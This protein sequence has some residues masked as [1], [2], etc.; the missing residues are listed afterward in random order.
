MAKKRPIETRTSRMAYCSKS[1]LPRSANSIRRFQSISRASN[2]GCVAAV[3]YITQFDF[4]GKRV[5]QTLSESRAHRGREG[6]RLRCSNCERILAHMKPIQ[7]VCD[8]CKK[9]V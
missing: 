9:T 8:I 3:F 1:L 4:Y 6:N 5:K 7:A 2:G